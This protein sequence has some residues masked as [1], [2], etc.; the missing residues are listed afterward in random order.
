[1]CKWEN[2]YFTTSQMNRYVPFLLQKKGNS[3]RFLLEKSPNHIISHF[4][5]KYFMFELICTGPSTARQ[6][7]I[8][9]SWRREKLKQKSFPP[10]I[11][12]LP[13]QMM[14]AN[15]PPLVDCLLF[16]YAVIDWLRGWWGINRNV[17]GWAGGLVGCC[18]ECTLVLHVY[19][20]LNLL[21]IQCVGCCRLLILAIWIVYDSTRFVCWEI[22]FT[23]LY[24]KYLTKL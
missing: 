17:G 7:H 9:Q 8:S 16:H 15:F 24:N 19:T 2:S 5:N 18:T 13:K 6:N 22:Y 12:Q 1:M 4:R 23:C 10:C 11:R 14:P 3:S 21:Y 20:G